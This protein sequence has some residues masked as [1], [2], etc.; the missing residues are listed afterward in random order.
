MIQNV[1]FNDAY[2]KLFHYLSYQCSFKWRVPL[3]WIGIAKVSRHHYGIVPIRWSGLAWKVL[4]V[5]FLLPWCGKNIILVRIV[6]EIRNQNSTS[7]KISIINTAAITFYTC[8]S[9]SSLSLPSWNLHQCL[10]PTGK[11]HPNSSLKLDNTLHKF[12][13]ATVH[14]ICVCYNDLE[15]FQFLVQTLLITWIID[16]L[17][18]CLQWVKCTF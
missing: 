4:K 12:T 2:L 13:H 7:S 8:V 5:V 11:Y 1:H 9:S 15:L 14:V 3:N 10:Y 18:E 6:L 16:A 17:F